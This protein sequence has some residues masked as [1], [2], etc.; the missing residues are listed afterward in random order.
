MD[1]VRAIE[2]VPTTS[3]RYYDDVPSAPI[4]IFRV[5]RIAAK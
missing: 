5:S 1:V 3:V 4:T 2:A